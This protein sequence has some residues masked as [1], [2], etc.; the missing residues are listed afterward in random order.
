MISVINGINNKNPTAQTTV[1]HTRAI[2]FK[3]NIFITF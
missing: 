3:L 1:P 2:G